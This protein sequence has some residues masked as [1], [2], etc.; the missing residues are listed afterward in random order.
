MYIQLFEE[1]K[2]D[3]SMTDIEKKYLLQ[4][5]EAFNNKYGT[6]LKI[7]NFDFIS[8]GTNSSLPT[9]LITN[10]KYFITNDSAKNDIEILKKLDDWGRD[11]NKIEI[12]ISVYTNTQ[13]LQNV[14]FSKYV[15][16]N[17]G[18]SA[19]MLFKYE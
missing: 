8:G 15:K 7:S 17:L 6:N 18:K 13:K 10:Y 16:N 1:F 14:V 2:N 11:Y 9:P 19:Q 4:G 5:L 12:G 3:S